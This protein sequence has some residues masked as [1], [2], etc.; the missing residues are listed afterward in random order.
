MGLRS[1]KMY[2]RDAIYKNMK[3]I[4]NEIDVI[5]F[6]RWNKSLRKSYCHRYVNKGMK[7]YKNPQSSD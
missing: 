1:A 4:Q 6:N 3:N 5:M 7:L 2:I